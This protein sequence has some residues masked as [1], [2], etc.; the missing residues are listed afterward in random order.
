MLADMK[1]LMMAAYYGISR[2]ADG[3]RPWLVAG[4]R[5]GAGTF[6]SCR[7]SVAGRDVRST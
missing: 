4:D 1:E 2:S 3:D 7:A 6:A 5:H